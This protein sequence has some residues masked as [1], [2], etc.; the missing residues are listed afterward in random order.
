[1]T[2]SPRPVHPAAERRA[3]TEHPL[4]PARPTTDR[5]AA[6]VLAA[7]ACVLVIT[8]GAV[9]LL[10]PAAAQA[11]A[12]ARNAAD[13]GALAG[14]TVLVDGLRGVSPPADP[15]AVAAALVRRN[16]A[17]AV[18]CAIDDTVNVTV[19]VRRELSGP[20]ARLPAVPAATAAAR[21]GP[22]MERAGLR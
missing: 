7:I 16:G 10:V 19:R 4:R 1:M 13:L 8:L 3:A 9:A 15:C 20:L 11:S 5:G 21:A 17:T 22:D 18:S 2:Q 6:T 12:V 14:A